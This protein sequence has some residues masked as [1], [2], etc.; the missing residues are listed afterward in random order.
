[1]K[2]PAPANTVILQ[3]HYHTPGAAVLAAF[4]VV[5]RAGHLRAATDYA[6]DRRS[7]AGHDLL[8]C[9]AGAGTVRVRGKKFT[10]QTGELVWING[11]EPHTHQ[12]D[13]TDPWELLWLRMDGPGLEALLRLLHA[14][15][16]PVFKFSDAAAVRGCFRRILRLMAGAP[17]HREERIYEVVAR[18]VAILRRSRQTPDGPNG[19]AIPKEMETVIN[20]MA[21]YPH[22]RWSAAELAR[23][24]GMSVPRFYRA[25]RQITG[26]SPIDWLRRERINLAKRRLLESEDSI[27]AVAEQA[28]YNSP[29]F[30]S[31]DFKRHTG[32]SP[33][34]FRLQERG[35]RR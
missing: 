2:L 3:S 10:V 31:R 34:G 8:F 23:L 28:G 26:S 33:T 15:E 25:F 16:N 24:A 32:Q 27:K 19:R 17:L 30:F 1:M 9:L 22:Q 4:P 7:S 12:A 11:Y 13:P 14:D 20:R 29:F 6:V 21:L 35:T 18:L 5:L